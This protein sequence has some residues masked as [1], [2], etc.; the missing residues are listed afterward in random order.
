VVKPDN[1]YK[2][3]L[4]GSEKKSGS[5]KEDWSFLKPKE[6][7][8]PAVSK[9]SDWVD[10]AMTD[11]PDDHKPAGYDDIPKTIVDPEAEKP[12]DWNDEDD[13]AWEAPTI[14]NPE[15]KGPWKPKRI[16]NPA[17]KGPW[18][19]PKIANPEFVDNDHLY[20]YKSFAGVG[21]DIWQ[22]KSGTT[23]RNL[24]ITDSLSEA[25]DFSAKHFGDAAQKAEKDAIQKE[26]DDEA[27]KAKADREAAEAAKGSDEDEDEDGHDEL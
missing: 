19:H 8:D 3:Y 10:E 9:P 16:S 25:Q 24:V 18:V 23:F 2:V 4:D 14:D 26:K 27:A 20:R 6:I 15:Y 5:L 17:Y 12:E 13:G 7:E 11:D 21:I 22:V 1:T